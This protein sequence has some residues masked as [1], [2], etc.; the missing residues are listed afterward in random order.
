[1]LISLNSNSSFLDLLCKAEQEEP[2]PQTGAHAS[3]RPGHKYAKREWLTDHWEY[4]YG[5]AP[6]SQH[7]GMGHVGQDSHTVD[8]P[9]HVDTTKLTPQ[10]AYEQAREHHLKTPGATHAGRHPVSGDDISFDVN[11]VIPSKKL[12]AN[13]HGVE[14][15]AKDKEGKSLGKFSSWGA[16]ERW[17]KI[18]PFTKEFKDDSGK[19]MFTVMP[20][21]GRVDAKSDRLVPRDMVKKEG[22]QDPSR[23]NFYIKMQDAAGKADRLYRSSFDSASRLASQMQSNR[24]KL[25]ASSSAP[26]ISD[27][28][29]SGTSATDLLN[30]GNIPWAPLEQ[31]KSG[32]RIQ[33][34]FGSEQEKHQFINRLASENLDAI[35]GA[36]NKLL[37]SMKSKYPGIAHKL[38]EDAFADLTGLS[39]GSAK[40]GAQTGDQFVLDPHSGAY[41]ALESAINSFDPQKIKYGF[42][43]YLRSIL[44]G[45]FINDLKD[46]KILG[47]NEIN[48]IDASGGEDP[49]SSI[50]TELLGGG[51]KILNSWKKEQI[52]RLQEWADEDNTF[53]PH[54]EDLQRFLTHPDFS[55]RAVPHFL[56]YL[57]SW[58]GEEYKDDP[59]RAQEF[60]NNVLYKEMIEELTRSLD[61]LI[62]SLSDHY[63]V[64][65]I[66][67]ELHK[68]EKTENNPNHVY[69]HSEGDANNPRFYYNDEKGNSVRYTNAPDGHPDNVSHLGEA[70]LHSSEPA[71]DKNPDFFTADG[72]KLNRAPFPG[73]EMMWNPNYHPQDPKN[74]WAGRWVNPNTG[75]HEYS[76]VDSDVRSNNNLNIYR[77][78]SLLDAR[79]PAFRQHVVS[80]F[81]STYIKDHV[82][83]LCLALIDQGRF[84][85]N[86]IAMLTPESVQVRGNLVLL[87]YRILNCDP[88][89]IDSLLLLSS[90]RV[91]GEPLFSI[92]MVDIDGGTSDIRRPIGMNF[93]SA[94]M[95]AMGVSP[96]A[97]QTYHATQLYSLEFH[98]NLITLNLPYEQA[99][100]YALMRVAQELGYVFSSPEEMPIILQSVEQN[101][102]DPVV[103]KVLQM[104][105]ESHMPNQAAVPTVPPIDGDLHVGVVSSYLSDRTPEEKEF[106]SFMHTFPIHSVLGDDNVNPT[107]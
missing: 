100:N 99:H 11:S 51:K 79:L 53:R 24:Q 75:D 65:A 104:S 98:K 21:V 44:G 3:P 96:E 13:P 33:V 27:S 58:A 88:R 49:A 93:I 48:V 61:S 43:G 37:S 105:A 73:A 97:F 9:E 101:L 20:N 2:T 85:M 66:K 70:A 64:E 19:T 4:T 95:N 67:L 90:G 25:I 22:G 103:V 32:G 23:Y 62:K 26:S 10:Q 42:K 102:I 30:S 36:A 39:Q 15:Q 92:P 14:I 87:G 34:K 54:A 50:H 106:S 107:S 55:I 57:S 18:L 94:V 5:N 47:S 76:Y 80:L 84:S 81:G 68:S 72:R 63:G 71:I 6:H 78:N 8:I 82:V 12:K 46:K 91:P 52:N 38:D 7:H 74:M 29:Q 60:N 1:M 69:S 86:D 16:V 83:G 89:I 77:M 31:D 41:G 40:I 17:H 28:L 45:R 35:T 56:D 59:V